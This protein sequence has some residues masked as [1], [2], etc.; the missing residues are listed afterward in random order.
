M[1]NSLQRFSL[2]INPPATLI[3]DMFA[4]CYYLTPSEIS[5][6]VCD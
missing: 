5:N 1:R 6:L 4:T 2:P 3:G